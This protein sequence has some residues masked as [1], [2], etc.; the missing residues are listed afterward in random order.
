MQT[1]NNALYQTVDGLIRAA[2]NFA[3]FSQ[4][5]YK[6]PQK[7]GG[8]TTDLVSLVTSLTN[9]INTFSTGVTTTGTPV[10]GELAKFSGADSITNGDLSGDVTTAGTLATTLA[11]TAVTPGS[12]TS[13][14]LTVDSKGRITAAANGSGGGGTGSN[15]VAYKPSTTS[16]VNTTTPTDD[17]DLFV[18]VGINEI[19]SVN[20]YL[21][22][23]A[24]SVGVNI[25]TQFTTPTGGTFYWGGELAFGSFSAWNP[26][27]TGG[28]N[29][30]LTTTGNAA[31]GVGTASPIGLHIIGLYVGGA[32]A[33]N[34]KFQW[35]QNTL[36]ASNSISVL[37]SSSIVATR[38]K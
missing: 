2:E 12:Y 19:H 37:A 9:L 3:G 30:V 16:R 11:D 10:A 6:A 28:S 17:P 33:G 1:Q 35:A 34:L 13:T 25:S 5:Q 29:P 23:T 36:D 20:L 7:L 24:A 32:N 38:I 8:G 21:L 15:T 31:S 27:G 14:D 26:N 18:P 22:L 4:Q